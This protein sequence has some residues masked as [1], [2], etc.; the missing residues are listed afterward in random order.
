MQIKR[1]DVKVGFT[2]ACAVGYE[3]LAPDVETARAIALQRLKSESKELE[4][5][6]NFTTTA[7]EI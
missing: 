4:F 7:S 6:G 1:F 5:M 3:I 2:K